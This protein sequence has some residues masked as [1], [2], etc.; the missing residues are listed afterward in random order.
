MRTAA[1]SALAI[2]GLVACPGACLWVCPPLP[3][4]D[5]SPAPAPE[6]LPGVACD[7]LLAL[8]EAAAE[9]RKEVS[10]QYRD[11]PKGGWVTLP[12]G[13][14]RPAGGAAAQLLDALH[15]AQ[16]AEQAALAEW[17]ACLDR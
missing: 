14:I 2:V 13:T 1:I 8:Y 11:A 17:H 3:V 15:E 6:P 5:E 9:R 7:P 16:D 12:D 4:G 10:D